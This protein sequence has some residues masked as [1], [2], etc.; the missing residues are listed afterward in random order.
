MH[1]LKSPNTPWLIVGLGNPGA[2]YAATPHNLGFMVVEVL[3]ERQ[4]LPLSKKTLEAHWGKGR[5]AEAAVILAQPTTYMNLSGRAVAK[6]LRYFGLSATDLVIIHDD[7]DVPEGRVKLV[8]GGGAGG[9]RGVLSVAEAVGS[10]EFYR[11]KLG[12][13]RPPGWL[14]PEDFVLKPFLREEWEA[15][16]D[17]VDRGAR[18]VVTLITAGLAAAQNQFHGDASNSA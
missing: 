9:H 11:V 2:K 13:G 5:L 17:L 16:A 10:P 18:A 8:W 14:D 3:A 1:T 12:L 4:D 7:L 15:V 6:L